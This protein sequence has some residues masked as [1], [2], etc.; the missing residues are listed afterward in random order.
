L[1][2]RDATTELNALR[3]E[4]EAERAKATEFAQELLRVRGELGA[5]RTRERVS[6]STLTAAA[7]RSWKDLEPWLREQGVEVVE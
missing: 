2:Y 7:Q 5:E 1:Q 6:M 3:A 4:L